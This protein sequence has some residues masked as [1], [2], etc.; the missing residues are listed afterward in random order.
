MSERNGAAT[1]MGNPLTQSCLYLVALY[2]IAAQPGRV[3]P[4]FSVWP[5][6]T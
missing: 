1:F 3:A 6:A 2:V 4:L 5:P